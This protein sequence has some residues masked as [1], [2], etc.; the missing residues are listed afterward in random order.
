MDRNWNDIRSR[1]LWITAAIAARSLHTEMFF[2]GDGCPN[3]EYWV[4]G[5]QGDLWDYEQEIY[6]SGLAIVMS[7][8]RSNVY[9]DTKD[10]LRDAVTKLTAESECKLFHAVSTLTR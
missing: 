10:M 4:K 7:G 3:H 1:H 5:L 2:H 8:F 6:D 9:N